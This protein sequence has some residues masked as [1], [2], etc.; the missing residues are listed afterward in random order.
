MNRRQFITAAI[1]A[2]VITPALPAV[3]EYTTFLLPEESIVYGSSPLEAAW[4]QINLLNEWNEYMV[5]VI[6]H[7]F[8]VPE[9]LL[10]RIER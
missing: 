8:A 7:S 1:G 2:A 4:E 5:R 10:G 9:R 6:A 3:A